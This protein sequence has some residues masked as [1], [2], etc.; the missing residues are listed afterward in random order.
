M[1]KAIKTELWKATHN[2]FFTLSLILGIGI[3]LL[4]VAQNVITVDDLVRRNIE[5]GLMGNG[6]HS[7]SLFTRWIAINGFTFGSVYFFLIWPVLAAMPHGWSY[8]QE[9]KTGVINQY[10]VRSTRK[11]Y[12]ISKYIAVFLSGGISVSLP[13]IVNLFLNALFCPATLPEVTHLLTAITDGYFL[14]AL[15]YT[16]PWCYCLIWCSVD[17]LFGGMGACLCFLVG[18]KIRF[19]VMVMLFPFAILYLMKML[20]SIVRRLTKWNIALT[21]LDQAIA[22]T[23]NA[24]PGWMIFASILLFTTISFVVGLYQV[25]KYEVA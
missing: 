17:F 13:I 7:I 23:L 16:H 8:A 24:N 1:K 10:L 2:T 6:T 20:S 22:G 4:D 11:T 25:E 14:S 19:P 3:I 12:F 15:F 5:A 21:P 18:H 9:V